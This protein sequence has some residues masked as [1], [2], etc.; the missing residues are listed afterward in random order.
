MPTTKL[1]RYDDWSKGDWGEL[2]PFNAPAGSFTGTNVIVYANGFIGPRAGLHENTYTGDTMQGNVWGIY[3]PGRI[4]K[5]VIIFVDDHIF[6]TSEDN[7]T[8]DVVADVATLDAVP[9]EPIVATWYDP[10]GNIY[11]TSP[12]DKVYS[13]NWATNVLTNVPVK[14]SGVDDAGVETVY[15]CRD[16]LYAA[17]DGKTGGNGGQY[18]YVSAAADFSNF[19]GGETFQV[20]YF[21]SVTSIMESQNSLNFSTLEST[22]NIGSG[23]GWYA[24]VGA[25][26][27]GDLRRVNTSV[28]AGAQQEV[29]NADNGN[30]YYW[31]GWNT[32][33]TDTPYL[34][35]ANGAKFN[36]EEFRHIR[37]TGSTRYGYFNAPDKTLIYV[38]DQGNNAWMRVNGVWTKHHF[39]VDVSGPVAP[40][41]AGDS[42]LLAYGAPS[43]D[44]VVYEML[45]RPSGP[46]PAS[47]TSNPGDN[48]NSPIDALF[49]LPA[50]Q[51]EGK[52]VR[53]RRVFV[54]FSKFDLDHA[55]GDNEFTVTVRSFG[56]YNLPGGS[57][58]GT[59]ETSQTWSEDQNLAGALGTLD[60]F[61]ARVGQQGKSQGFQIAI[62]GIKGVMIR[63][64][65]VEIDEDDGPEGRTI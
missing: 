43:T 17:G 1:V 65:S 26:P 39:E 2:S 49:E 15:L 53:V 50:Y 19:G 35:Q 42:F 52:E 48:S 56:Q 5:P 16:R 63:S 38:S 64:I 61:V 59:V 32:S 3:T 12:G 57:T 29:V 21:N 58:D 27:Q 44:V 11:F 60:R 40:T 45:S 10:N 41:E 34:V 33:P 36:E 24:L 20:G 9:T 47:G 22:N 6:S 31:T 18:V 51:S 13:I 23:V 37:L 54:D 8:L 7:T 4:G 55:D 14:N 30:F 46:V 25:T 62:S 28:A